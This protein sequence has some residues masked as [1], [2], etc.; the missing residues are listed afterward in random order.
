M[1]D[2][3]LA[4]R[5]LQL[6][7]TEMLSMHQIA[8]Y[9]GMCPKTVSRI[10]HAEGVPLRHAYHEM[11]IAPYRRLIESWYAEHPKLKASQVYDRLLALGFTGSYP[12]VNRATRKLRVKKPVMFHERVL[13]PAA[14]TMKQYYAVSMIPVSEGLLPRP[15]TSE[16]QEVLFNL[17]SNCRW[18]N[19]R[20]SGK[21]PLDKQY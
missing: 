18:V 1:I 20:L 2:A 13:L 6:Y 8:A 11:L 10:I 12:T 7:Q 14:L 3:E 16:F 17:H 5:V 21:N 19:S 4:D 9:S 15:A